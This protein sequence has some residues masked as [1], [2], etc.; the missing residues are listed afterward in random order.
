MFVLF[1]FVES[2]IKYGFE[3]LEGIKFKVKIVVGSDWSLV[4]SII[5]I[6]CFSFY[7]SSSFLVGNEKVLVLYFKKL[8][9]NV[10]NDDLREEIW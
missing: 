8:F 5:K 10:L 4:R 2:L 1:G 3:G 7:F 9:E 6:L